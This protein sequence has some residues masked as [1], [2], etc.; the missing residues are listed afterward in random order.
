MNTLND[1]RIY[2][3]RETKTTQRR[4]NPSTLQPLIA[5]RRLRFGGGVRRGLAA[6]QE[7]GRDREAPAYDYARPSTRIHG[8]AVYG[9]D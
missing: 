5:A 9:N 8:P 4:H 1:R 2:G 6:Q 7:Q 3:Y